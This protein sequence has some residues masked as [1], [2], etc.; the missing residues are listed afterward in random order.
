MGRG[1][2]S[3]AYVLVLYWGEDFFFFFVN[4]TAGFQQICNKLKPNSHKHKVSSESLP[5]ASCSVPLRN[6]AD[7]CEPKA[8]FLQKHQK[9]QCW[10]FQFISCFVQIGKWCHK[11][12]DWSFTARGSCSTPSPADGVNTSSSCRFKLLSQPSK[13]TSVNSQCSCYD[14]LYKLTHSVAV[15]LLFPCHFKN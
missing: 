8:Y 6:S 1:V 14:M 11:W 4:V 12:S 2:N 7:I 9:C 15:V 10:L 5:D 3:Y 13:L